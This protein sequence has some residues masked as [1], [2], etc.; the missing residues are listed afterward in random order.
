M[1]EYIDLDTPLELYRLRGNQH[2]PIST[3]LQ[4]LLDFNKIPYTVANVVQVVR[5]KDCTHGTRL[6]CDLAGSEGVV[7]RHG[8]IAHR[9]DWFCA[10]G[11]KMKNIIEMEDDEDGV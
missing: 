3:T 2:E 7:C 5:C 9:L 8:N 10:D 11:A 4:E 1:S 6:V